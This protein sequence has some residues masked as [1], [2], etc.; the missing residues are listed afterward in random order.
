[1]TM[2]YLPTL[3]VAHGAPTFALEPGIA[4]PALAALG[5][6]LARP[7]AVLVISPHWIT[8]QPRVT[9]AAQ[10]HTMHDFGGFD[11]ALRE[12]RY[13]A[14]GRPALA[15]RTVALLRAAGWDPTPDPQR[16]LDH[17]AWVPMLYLYPQADV[18]VVQLSLP[19]RLDAEGAFAFGRS[20]APLAGENVLV[21]GSGS[22]THNLYELRP[23]AEQAADYAVEFSNWIRD[24][25][26]EGDQQR[27]LQALTIGPHAQRAHPTPE[28][29]WP[30]L[31]AAGAAHSM[32][33]ATAI[34]GGMTYAVLSMDS[35]L[36]G[37]DLQLKMGADFVPPV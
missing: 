32:R 22:L 26:R 36:F 34:D 29:F 10:P 28:H 37:Q 20:L 1:M 33:P 23:G 3:F 15:A 7:A 8:A 17:G 16:R 30:L 19:S 2:T 21:I 18:P 31:V 13:P 27:L 5:R 14:P 4:G 11:P 9:S 35:F 24:A 25:V 12:I 6:S